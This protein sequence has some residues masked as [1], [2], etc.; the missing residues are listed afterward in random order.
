ML[1]RQFYSLCT[2]TGTIAASASDKPAIKGRF[3]NR[4]LERAVL[5]PGDQVHGVFQIK[6]PNGLGSEFYPG[7]PRIHLNDEGA[8]SPQR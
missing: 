8:I 1:S 3:G 5:R 2:A 7:A 6:T 4:D